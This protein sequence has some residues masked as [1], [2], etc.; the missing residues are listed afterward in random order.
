MGD[1]AT[2]HSDIRKS[3][4]VT[5]Y[6][7][8][9]QATTYYQNKVREEI[10]NN[11][12][13][14]TEGLVEGTKMENMIDMTFLFQN[15]EDLEYI[16]KQV[17]PD[18]WLSE[19]AYHFDLYTAFEFFRNLNNDKSE[20]VCVMNIKPAQSA[21]ENLL[22]R[23]QPLNDVVRSLVVTTNPPSFFQILNEFVSN[24][25]FTYW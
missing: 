25:D 22:L 9:G 16:K 21:F 5:L 7:L 12:S 20:F 24:S 14:P 10:N 13:I 11:S 19:L 6:D 18:Q 2:L 8:R 3:R 1:K 17:K 15:K 4:L 23:N